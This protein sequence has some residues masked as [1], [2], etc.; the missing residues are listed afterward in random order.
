MRDKKLRV[1]D[2]EGGQTV[3]G[4]GGWENRLRARL[5]QDVK[6]VGVRMLARRGLGGR[7]RTLVLSV[8]WWKKNKRSAVKER[9]FPIGRD[10]CCH[11]SEIPVSRFT[12]PTWF[13]VGAPL[14]KFLYRS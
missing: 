9:A 11:G 4:G 12:C 2:G 13:C 14:A 1:R 8:L 10:T 6:G 5:E 7:A 3:G